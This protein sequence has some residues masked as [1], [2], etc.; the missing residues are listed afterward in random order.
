MTNITDKRFWAIFIVGV[1]ILV[2]YLAGLCYMTW[3]LSDQDKEWS[4]LLYLF[5]GIETLAFSAVA[6]FFGR[7]VNRQRAEK[8]EAAESEAQGKADTATAKATQAEANGHALA[9]AIRS[10]AQQVQP[11]SFGARTENQST[12]PTVSYL[13]NLADKFFP[14]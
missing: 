10:L 4:R 1:L 6:F 14:A 5:T 3:H 11:V 8:A 7:E 9:T 13:A 12:Y 2:A